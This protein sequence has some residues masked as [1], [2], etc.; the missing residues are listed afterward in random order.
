[1]AKDINNFFDEE[2]KLT[3]WPAKRAMQDAALA[4]LAQLFE[5][6]RDYTELEVN[7]IL[8]GAHTFGDYFLLRRGLIES[9]WLCR[10]P[11]GSRYWKNP[12]REPDEARS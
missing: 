9:R 3:Q 7:A 1:M 8:G 5:P 6:G 2:G 12:D 11:D 10:T 4:R